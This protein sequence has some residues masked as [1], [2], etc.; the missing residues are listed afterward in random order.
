MSHCWQRR[1]PPAREQSRRKQVAA[2]WQEVPLAHSA[3][4]AWE[5]RPIPLAG[6]ADDDGDDEDAEDDGRVYVSRGDWRSR[7]TYV[8]DDAESPF[9]PYSLTD[10][11]ARKQLEVTGQANLS[12]KLPASADDCQQTAHRFHAARIEREGKRRTRAAR[13][14]TNSLLHRSASCSSDLSNHLGGGRQ[15]IRTPPE[16]SGSR[17]A[18]H[19]A[20][21][22]AGSARA[23]WLDS[24]GTWRDLRHATNIVTLIDE[25]PDRST[26]V[27]A[28]K[29]D[30]VHRR[31]SAA[32]ER[33]L[34]S[35][36]EHARPSVRMQTPEGYRYHL[37]QVRRNRY[38]A[39]ERA[40][41]VVQRQH[42]PLNQKPS[43]QWELG[44]SIWKVRAPSTQTCNRHGMCV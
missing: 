20:V 28:T 13:A 8:K 10:K 12:A 11:A 44:G 38:I 26:A 2:A 6:E 7:I 3:L 35:A 18:A 17:P 27:A 34:T 5:R 19:H 16:T 21:A 23:R 30:Y 42:R 43:R 41:A 1:H 4:V 25:A 40:A 31:Q 37:V 32:A 14:S 39:P 33:L 24:V 36:D 22:A 29:W 9:V 15:Q